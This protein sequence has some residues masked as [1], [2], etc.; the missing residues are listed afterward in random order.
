[1]AIC[2]VNQ[3]HLDIRALTTLGVSVKSENAIGYFGT[4]FKYAL[5]T[6][7]RN[8]QDV[9]VYAGDCIYKFEAKPTTIRGEAF[10]L[11]HMTVNGKKSRDL[12]I[13]TQL[14]RD[15]TLLQA[16]RELYCNCMDEGG[17]VQVRE[18]APRDVEVC[19][20]VDGL[21]FEYTHAQR[22]EIILDTKGKRRI[23][24]CVDLDVYE[25][26]SNQIWYKGVAVSRLN[27]PSLF[28]YNFKRHMDLTED[29]TLKDQWDARAYIRDALLLSDERK[30]LY[31]AITSS[32]T[33]EHGLEWHYSSVKP[34]ETFKSVIRAARSNPTCRIADNAMVFFYKTATDIADIFEEVKPTN[35]QQSHFDKAMSTLNAFNLVPNIHK[36]QIIFADNLPKQSGE[37]CKGKLIISTATLCENVRELIATILE[38]YIHLEFGVYDCSRS[39]QNKLFD[40]I[41]ELLNR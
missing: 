4:G 13:T 7:L 2:F 3:G 5:A 22:G 24:S 17:T 34:G 9:K 21:E 38:E 11:I 10:E 20:M 40:I 29:R 1:M 39:M 6:L 30:L 12:G 14:G 35:E 37:A 25:G 36:Y 27:R 8:G 28:T 26:G 33:M 19:V 41:T 15:W 16:Y 23:Y 32:D 31:P 18:R